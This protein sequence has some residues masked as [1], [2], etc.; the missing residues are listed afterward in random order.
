[1]PATGFRTGIVPIVDLLQGEA[2]MSDDVECRNASEKTVNR[3][4]IPG[5]PD[6]TIFHTISN[7][8]N[9]IFLKL[10]FGAVLFL[11]VNTSIFAATLIVTKTAD[12]NDGACNADC[13]L[14]EAIAA[15]NASAD[16]DVIVFD[17][18]VFQGAKTIVLAGTQLTITNNGSLRINGT[19]A[20][21]LTISGNNATGVIS[22]EPQAVVTINSLTITNGNTAGNGGGISN[23]GGNLTLNAAAVR[24]N[25]AGLGGGIFNNAVLVL[26]NT[27]IAD[28]HA[29]GIGGGIYNFFSGTL[30]ATDST[31][32]GNIVAD[33]IGGG[34]ANGGFATLA[35]V[36]ISG[37][38]V[39]AM[40]NPD[41]GMGGGVF[42]GGT[43]N[44]SNSTITGN[45]AIRGGSI[46]TRTGALSIV[47]STIS[48]NQAGRGSGICNGCSNF[49]SGGATADITNTTISINSAY[50]AGGGGIYNTA[51]NTVNL[52]Y[53]TLSGNAAPNAGGV[54]NLGTISAH[55]SIIGDNSATSGSVPDFQGILTSQGYNLIENTSGGT[56]T[57]TMTGNITGLDPKLGPLTNNGGSTLTRSLLPGSPAIDSADPSDFPATD[58]RNVTRP[59]NGDGV[60]NARSDM[61]AFEREGA[62][63]T[64]RAPFDFD[65]DGKSDIS[66]FRPSTNVWYDF[67]SSNSQVTEQIFGL[68][69]DIITPA[70]F[71]GDGKTDLGVFRPSSGDWWFKSSIT[72]VFSTVHWGANGDI[73]RPSDFDGDDEADY[74]IF[75][76]SNNFWYRLGS[77]GAVSITQ[78]GLSGDK[79]LTGDF[80]G[81]GKSDLT[82]FR[83]SP[84]DWWWQSSID[85]VQR[86]T[87]W[88]TSTDVPAA[89]DYDGDN[90]TDFA[91]YRPSNGTWYI[92]NS[93]DF[94]YTIINF[95]LAEDKPVPA[96]YDGDG[97]VDIAVFRPST[98]VWYLL[99]STAGFMAMQFGI[100]TDIPTP[101]AYIN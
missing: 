80:D 17:T 93:S 39:G 69:G 53:T 66:V 42:T 47:S 72:G 32:S 55:G 2:V 46:G 75:R 73:P 101:N 81:D 65:G 99:R 70:D 76:P 51:N 91:V 48:N 7:N 43:L 64:L 21:L 94:S 77:T 22:I 97:K 40:T 61:G 4:N 16:D 56:I 37:N 62:T 30:T 10:L 19:G 87:H 98:G 25:T 71:D 11:C 63:T 92:F 45:S 59:R 90:K 85:N 78:F 31:V 18:T 23:N 60:G 36:T 95:G 35:G 28:N 82:I 3:M 54:F 68:S 12:T 6:G 79:P 26:N 20:S 100:S 50:D 74:I 86:A 8:L 96:D 89:G 33:G 44:A 49:D 57:G 13:S 9:K 24:N 29:G 58:Q 34:I 84:G 41:G 67:Q 1:M 5:V 27:T 83:P 15:A 38:S 52:K 88:G 14:R